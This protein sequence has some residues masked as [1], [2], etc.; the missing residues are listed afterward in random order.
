MKLKIFGLLAAVLLAGP[1]SALTIGDSRDLGSIEFGIPSGDADRTNYVNHLI[2]MALGSTDSALG[3]TFHRSN[4]SCGTCP[5]AV[6][7]FE[8][9]G[10]VDRFGYW[11]FHVPFCEVRR[12]QLWCCGLV[13]R[14]SQRVYHNPCNRRRLWPLWVDSLHR[15]QRLHRLH[16]LDRLDGFDWLD[17]QR[18]GTG[19]VDDPAGPRPAGPRLLTSPQGWLTPHL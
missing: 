18:A 6:F 4:A 7:A 16:W 12:P 10:Y 11:W 13:R 14:W 2:D 15:L 3:Q 19:I 17:R 1:A 5:D 8:R 9:H